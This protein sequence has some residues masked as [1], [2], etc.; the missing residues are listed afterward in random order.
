MAFRARE[1]FGTFEKRAPG[2]VVAVAV[3]LVLA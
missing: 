3:A 1:I 2:V